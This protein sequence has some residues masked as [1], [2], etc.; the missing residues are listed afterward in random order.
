MLHLN[1]SIFLHS[2]VIFNHTFHRSFKLRNIFIIHSNAHRQLSLRVL[3]YIKVPD[4][5]KHTII[6]Y[7][8]KLSISSEAMRSDDWIVFGVAQANY[9]V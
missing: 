5:S 4:S 3:Q 6:F 1:G 7:L 2:E 9:F 8:S